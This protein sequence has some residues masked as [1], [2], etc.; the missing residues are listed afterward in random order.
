M[1]A[2][3][4]GPCPARLPARAR[5]ALLIVVVGLAGACAAGRTSPAPTVPPRDV[6]A[7]ARSVAGGGA[8][9]AGPA[10]RCFDTA[11]VDAA[12]VRLADRLLLEA[13]DGEALYTLAGGLKPLSSGRALTLR[14][15]PGSDRAALDSLEAVRRALPVL[16]CGEIGVV[17]HAFAAAPGDTTARRSFEVIVHHRAAVAAVIA[18]HATVFGPLGITPAADVREVLAAVEHA[19]RAERWR[20]YGLL[21]G[22]PDAAV[23]FFVRAGVEGDRTRTLVPR[24]FRR[25]ETF[26]KFPLE[27]DGPPVASSFVY[28][29]PKDAPESPADRALQA[30]ARPIYRRYAA[31]RA[32]RVGADSTG[33]LALWREWLGGR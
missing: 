28:A 23:D 27:R 3:A 16:A 14:L 30:A 24:D 26:R 5:D 7:S 33:A 15:A 31:E 8:A 32:R 6:A 13:G 12:T 21:F 9:S 19:P 29:V 2:R 25:I 20:G 11:G 18:R 4:S 10:R 22:Y 17:L 1:P